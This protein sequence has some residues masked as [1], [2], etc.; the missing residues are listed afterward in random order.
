MGTNFEKESLKDALAL[1]DPE[2]AQWSAKLFRHI[3]GSNFI[4]PITERE[5]LSKET[6]ATL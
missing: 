3:F 4:P 1:A 5:E 6:G 2:I